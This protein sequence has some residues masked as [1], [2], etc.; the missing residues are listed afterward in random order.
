MNFTE[1]H[2]LALRNLNSLKHLDFASFGVWSMWQA[3][4]LIRSCI[5]VAVQLHVMTV[6]E[7]EETSEWKRTAI[8]ERQFI[9]IAVRIGAAITHRIFEFQVVFVRSR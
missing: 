9:Q 5:A 1:N 4:Q 6:P 3:V 2:I 7:K 8:R